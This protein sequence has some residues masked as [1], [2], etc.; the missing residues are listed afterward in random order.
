M[1]VPANRDKSS[2]SKCWLEPVTCVGRAGP[3]VGRTKDAIVGAKNVVVKTNDD[4]RECENMRFDKNRKRI[5]MR[6]KQLHYIFLQMDFLWQNVIR[7]TMAKTTFNDV[8]QK[9]SE[10][11]L[12]LIS[13]LA[14]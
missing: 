8:D 1:R 2:R 6:C 3:H 5:E 12:W 13:S 4:C 11:K 14:G 7:A 10:T 9:Q